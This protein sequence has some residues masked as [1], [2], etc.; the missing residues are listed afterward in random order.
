[1]KVSAITVD[2]VATYLRLEDST[3]PILPPILKVAKE[4]VSNYTG[5]RDQDISDTFTATGTSDGFKLSISPIVEDSQIVKLN[6]VTQT[7]D[8]DYT[9]DRIKGIVGFT[10]MP[11]SE[12]VVDA[13]Y[14]YGLDG[15]EDFYLA[16]M[17]LCQDMYD[18]RAYLVDKT[19]VNKV[20][21]SVLD[22]HRTNLLPS[23]E[24]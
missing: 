13:D 2:D 14:E 19:N 10:D 3:D 12:D 9:I 17:V 7:A 18:N 11:D 5:I 8:V 21:S 22:M 6:D 20:V 15:F 4:F 16:I 24:V 1:M 23:A